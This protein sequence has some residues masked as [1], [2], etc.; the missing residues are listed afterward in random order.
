MS[1]CSHSGDPRRIA[2]AGVD[3]I[4]FADGFEPEPAAIPEGRDRAVTSSGRHRC[5]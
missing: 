1:A 2:I 5:R 3:D 4:E